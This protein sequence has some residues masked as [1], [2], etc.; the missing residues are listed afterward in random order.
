MQNFDPPRNKNYQTDLDEIW[1][2]KS[3]QGPKGPKKI[4]LW[5]D[6]PESGRPH[7]LFPPLWAFFSA[8]FD[9]ATAQTKRPIIMCNTSTD[10]VSAEEVPL[11]GLKISK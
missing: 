1:N 10:A 11:R 3:D 4:S 8:P 5:S 9:G 2:L 6:D 7:P